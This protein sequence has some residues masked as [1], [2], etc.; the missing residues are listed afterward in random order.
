M[1]YLRARSLIRMQDDAQ[2]EQGATRMRGG[3]FEY[4]IEQQ[5]IRARADA[6]QRVRSV[7]PPE[8]LGLDSDPDRS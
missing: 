5:Q 3:V 4:L 1:E 7:I 2:V 8:W 6:Q